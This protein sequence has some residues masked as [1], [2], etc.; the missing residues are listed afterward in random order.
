MNFRSDLKFI[1]SPL[2]NSQKCLWRGSPVFLIFENFTF[3]TC[4]ALHALPTLGA[5]WV[6]RASVDMFT[7][8]ASTIINE[9]QV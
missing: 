8:L 9:L 5:L 4:L 7:S 3:V 6:M 1:N 2:P